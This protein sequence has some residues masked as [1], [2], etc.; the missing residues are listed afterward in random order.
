MFIFL[1]NDAKYC[2]EPFSKVTWVWIEDSAASNWSRFTG[3][4]FSS[5]FI[6]IE[7]TVGEKKRR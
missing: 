4:L 6:V 7:S 5:E 3:L 1:E 2:Q